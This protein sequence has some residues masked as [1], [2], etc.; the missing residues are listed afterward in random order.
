MDIKEVKKRIVE[1]CNDISSEKYTLKT[2]DDSIQYMLLG[3]CSLI[4][5]IGSPHIFEQ[6][7]HIVRTKI[8]YERQLAKNKLLKIKVLDQWLKDYDIIDKFKS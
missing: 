5:Y 8:E 4:Q 3:D 7:F 2:I 1:R 6:L